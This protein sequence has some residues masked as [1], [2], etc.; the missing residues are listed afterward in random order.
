MDFF[1]KLKL[2]PLN[3]L[4][5]I[6]LL[7][8]VLILLS[9]GLQFIVSPLK[10]LQSKLNPSTAFYGNSNQSYGKEMAMDSAMPMMSARNVMPTMDS[11]SN[12][13]IGD[14][15]EDFEVTEY[16]GYIETTNLEQTCEKINVL[17]PLDYVIFE[18]A[19]QQEKNCYYTFKVKKDKTSEILTIIEELN[20][21]ELSENI[22]TIKGRID[23][24]TS[25]TDI[26]KKKKSSIEKTLAEATTT[27]DEITELA[28]TNKDIE[29]LAKVIDSKLN[30]IERLTQNIIN[31]N[32]QLERLERSKQL[33][34]DKLNY[35]RFSVNITEK[36][37]FDINQIK[38][39]WFNSIRTS[40][41]DINKAIQGISVNLLAFF[42]LLLQYS[43]YFFIVILVAKLYWKWVKGI[44]KK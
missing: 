5:G 34:L 18:N 1:K 19:N 17:K 26:L 33:Q 16:N 10:S 38:D 13:Y 15:A 31:I 29:S 27:Y 23:D 21:K 35:T 32:A 24:Y 4:K 36:K 2:T 20:P 41:N 11:S 44:W 30:I 37:Y 9:V 3:I 39:S 12:N 14:N 6:G 28:R 8:I 7:F 43:V 25:E 22:Y 40:I 42:I